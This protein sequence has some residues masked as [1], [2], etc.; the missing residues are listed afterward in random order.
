[1]EIKGLKWGNVDSRLD[2]KSKSHTQKKK[3]QNFR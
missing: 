1:M 3:M 2:V